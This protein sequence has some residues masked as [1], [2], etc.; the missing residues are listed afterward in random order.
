M[1]RLI[2]LSGLIAVVS[3][4]CSSSNPAET[5]P[6]P[7]IDATVEARAK[8]LVAAQANDKPIAT[9]VA[10]SIPTKP[11]TVLPASIPTKQPTMTPTHIPF[12]GVWIHTELVDAITD[13]TDQFLS[14][15]AA[16]EEGRYGDPIVMTI[17]CLPTGTIVSILWETFIDSD[18]TQVIQRWDS[19]DAFSADWD[20]NSDGD[21]TYLLNGAADSLVGDMLK[22]NQ[23]IV[24]VSP[25]SGSLLTATFDLR[26]LYQ[27]MK[28]LYEG[29]PS[30]LKEEGA[31]QPTAA[32][33]PEPTLV[34]DPSSANIHPTTCSSPEIG[35]S[36]KW[37]Q[38][39]ESAN[40][41]KCV[42]PFG[43]LIGAADGI[44]DVYIAQA[45][46]IAAEILDPDMDGEPNDS[47]VFQLVSDYTTAW[48]PMPTDRNSWISGG[49]EDELSQKLGSYG[50]QLPQWWMIGDTEFGDLNPDQ[51]AKAVMVEEIIHFMTQFGYSRAYPEIFGVESWNS[52]I[53]K[54]TKRA[55]CDWWQHPEND[56]PNNPRLYGDCS[57]PD[58]DVTEFYHQVLVTKAGMEPGW[59]G[60][61][62]PTTPEEL[63][64]KLS[65]ALKAAMEQPKYNQINKPLVFSYPNRAVTVR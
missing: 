37:I 48:I 28:P 49:V 24:Q 17:G 41:T 27:A 47:T 50:L 33:V 60:I 34:P 6:T 42:R 51:H 18:S 65:P 61:G 8:E 29:C 43:V 23:L 45:A 62:F 38:T 58:C 9:E 1:K 53:A 63:D 10:T 4:A 11:A 59:L 56:C 21:M 39:L 12:T 35:I 30:L 54:E 3:I 2:L 16:E 25:Y 19:A 26:G 7:V 22:S 32:A 31:S 44:P 14:A 46:K 20:L 55:S 57:D 5:E 64:L 52:L 15:V 40:F 13:E 36:E